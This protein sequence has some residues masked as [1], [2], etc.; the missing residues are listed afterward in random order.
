VIAEGHVPS[1]RERKFG[2]S[3]DSKH[4]QLF[5]APDIGKKNTRIFVLLF[6][7]PRA[8]IEQTL[9][10]RRHCE[11]DKEGTEGGKSSRRNTYPVTKLLIIG[12]IGAI[13][14]H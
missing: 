13:H 5:A 9:K 4:R 14:H 12:V 6:I 8:A 11:E 10:D 3:S 2:S 7:A 1:V